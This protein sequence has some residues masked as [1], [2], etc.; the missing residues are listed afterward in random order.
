MTDY[1]SD[2]MDALKTALDNELKT[3]MFYVDAEKKAKSKFSKKTFSF[4]AEQELGHIQKIKKFIKG[5]DKKID[6][7]DIDMEV[8]EMFFKKSK[9]F[10]ESTVEHFKQ[11]LKADDSDLNIYKVGKEIEQSG[12][13]FYKKAFEDANT[14]NLKAFFKFLMEQEQLHYQLLENSLDYIENPEGFFFD[15]ENW[16]FEG[17]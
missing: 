5:A 2:E 10:F 16:N 7:I 15:Q 3:H 13:D 8:A 6:Q 4:L 9:D 17:G 12:F 14:E 11:K 1:L